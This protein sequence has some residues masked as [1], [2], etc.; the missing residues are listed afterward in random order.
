MEPYEEQCAIFNINDIQYLNHKD[1]GFINKYTEDE[2][3]SQFPYHNITQHHYNRYIT[4]ANQIYEF[5]KPYL[6]FRFGEIF[7]SYVVKDGDDALL[8]TKLL[9]IKNPEKNIVTR[10]Q[11]EELMDG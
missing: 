4:V 9:D 6:E 7:E 10:K 3:R 1:N 5:N 11:L 2:R 8:L